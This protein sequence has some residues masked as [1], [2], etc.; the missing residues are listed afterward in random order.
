MHNTMLC[1]RGGGR[2]GET[3]P[4]K[5]LEQS[6]IS[7]FTLFTCTTYPRFQ[8]KLKKDPVSHLSIRADLTANDKVTQFSYNT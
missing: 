3:D 4:E 7:K 2:G 5:E 1:C 6:V 8:V